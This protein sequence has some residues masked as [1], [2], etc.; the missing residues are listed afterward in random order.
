MKCPLKKIGPFSGWHLLI[1]GW[2]IWK[3]VF[4]S[5]RLYRQERKCFKF[6]IF[7][8]YLRLSFFSSGF[9][10]FEKIPR[11][12]HFTTPVY[13]VSGVL[14]TSIP[15]LITG[16]LKDLLYYCLPQV[17]LNFKPCRTFRLIRIQLWFPPQQIL[18]E[19]CLI[20]TLPP[21]IM[22]VKHGMSPIGPLPF[23]Y[24]HFPLNHDYGRSR[25]IIYKALIKHGWEFMKISP[26]FSRSWNLKKASKAYKFVRFFTL[27][28]PQKQNRC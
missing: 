7:E 20:F 26:A 5:S 17:W 21:I 12:K 10:W 4:P 22:E 13:G 24:S 16:F 9:C 3:Y 15:V 28:Q 25:V 1:L 11:R 2:K 23:K 14:S 8:S 18:L 27:K 6:S 19:E